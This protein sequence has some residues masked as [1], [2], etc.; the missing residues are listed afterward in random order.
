MGFNPGDKLASGDPGFWV[1]EEGNGGTVS[2][3]NS[4]NKGNVRWRYGFVS[5]NY[6]GTRTYSSVYNS[7]KAT[8]KFPIPNNAYKLFMV[9]QGSPN[10]YIKSAWDDN[11]TTDAQFPYKVKFTITSLT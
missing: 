1:K 7:A 9:V 10:T 3:Y 11:E 5:L 2:T 6:D 8:A 4:V